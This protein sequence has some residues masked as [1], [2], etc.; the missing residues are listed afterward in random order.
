L[1]AGAADGSFHFVLPAPADAITLASRSMRPADA[2]GARDSDG[3]HLGVFVQG[4]EIDGAAR[5]LGDLD[6]VGWHDLEGAGEHVW[7]WTNGHAHLPSAACEIVVW[8]SAAAT[9]RVE[10]EAAALAGVRAA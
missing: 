1:P 10:P 6:G 7:R 3:R 5:S 4:L 9:Y 8:L 2:D